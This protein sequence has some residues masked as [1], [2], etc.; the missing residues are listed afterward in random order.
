MVNSLTSIYF[1]CFFEALLRE[2]IW[3]LNVCLERVVVGPG[4]GFDEAAV[5]G[6]I[7][8][9]C[10][11]SVLCRSSYF[12]CFRRAMLVLSEWLI[13]CLLVCLIILGTIGLLAILF[14]VLVCIQAL[15]SQSTMALAEL[16]SN[17][18]R[19]CLNGDSKFIL[20]LNVITVI[21]RRVYKK[22]GTSMVG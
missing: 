10:L 21:E 16:C 15:M 20:I 12:F 9:D 1:G 7:F 4:V 22:G 17:W 6:A 3:I 11:R 19:M 14:L 18:P 2:R 8:Y 13:V 5:G